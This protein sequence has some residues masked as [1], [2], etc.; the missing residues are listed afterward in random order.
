MDR[1]IVKKLIML[2][3]ST[4]ALGAFFIKDHLVVGRRLC[5]Y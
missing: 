4:L 5:R 2:L 1:N 3:V